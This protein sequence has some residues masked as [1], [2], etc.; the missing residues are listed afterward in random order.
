MRDYDRQQAEIENEMAK[1]REAYQ[2]EREVMAFSEK[3]HNVIQ[4]V[5]EQIDVREGM[6]YAND[7]TKSM[8]KLAGALVY[9]LEDCCEI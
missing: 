4:D 2:K 5:L 7:N 9:V 3:L 1:R 8:E 6:M